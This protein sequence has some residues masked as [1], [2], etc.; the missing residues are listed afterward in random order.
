MSE[1]LPARSWVSAWVALVLVV[2][3]GA[4][5]AFFL[6]EDE[7]PRVG[8]V[9][10]S[11]T[12]LSR[13]A[14]GE[15]FEQRLGTSV[16]IDAVPGETV[17]GQVTAAE[18]LLREGPEVLVINLGTNDVYQRVPLEESMADYERI[19][20]AAGDR[21]VVVTN[22][23]EAMT[24]RQRGFDDR[25]TAFNEALAALAEERGLRMV[26]WSGAVADHIEAHRSDRDILTDTIHPTPRGATLLAQLTADAVARCESMQ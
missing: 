26:D 18:E 23:N 22:L 20:D 17:A 4:A 21:C 8:V 24:G 10:D 11:I 25:L 16:L 5:A 13:S 9:G 2:A 7:S 19:L 1:S 15:E 3:V 12:H 6:E 14:F